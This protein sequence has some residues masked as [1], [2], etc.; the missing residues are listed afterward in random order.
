LQ[1]AGSVVQVVVLERVELDR[2]GA[3]RSCD[4]IRVVPLSKLSVQAPRF[5]PMKITYFQ[6]HGNTI[7]EVHSLPKGIVARVESAAF[8]IKLVTECQLLN[9]AIDIFPCHGALWCIGINQSCSDALQQRDVI[10]EAVW[11]RFATVVW[12]CLMDFVLHERST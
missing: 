4:R 1:H 10:P 2:K 7:P 9:L 12:F 5:F 8:I 3:V 6:I 11:V